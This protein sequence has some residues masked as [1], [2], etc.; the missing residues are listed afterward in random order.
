MKH[1]DS[2]A[3][4]VNEFMGKLEDT[5]EKVAPENTDAL[6][7]L[8]ELRD[9]ANK[10]S[11][12][13]DSIDVFNLNY[14]FK[15]IDEKI[16]SGE[17]S[18]YAACRFDMKRFSVVNHQFG[19]EDGTKILNK[20]IV[21]LQKRLGED[22]C[23]CRIQGDTF[24]VL[25]R[26]KRISFVTNYLSGTMI[27]LGLKYKKKAMLSTYA[28]Y[29]EIVGEKTA[30]E[31]MDRI[32]MAWNIAKHVKRVPYVF[33]DEK[34][35]QSVEN[36]K[37]VESVFDEA[38][39]NEEFMVYY[40]PKVTLKNYR[41][42]GAEALCRW[43]HNGEMVLPY[44]F[45]PV[46]EQSNMICELDFYMLEHVCRDLKRWRDEG[47]ELVKI[48]VNLSR[49]HLGDMDLVEHVLEIVDRYGI[50]HSYIELEL[51]ETTTDVDFRE[52]KQIVIAFRMQGFSVAVDDFGVGYSSLNLIREM[53]WKVLKIDKSFLPEGDEDEDENN[54]KRVMLKHIIGMAQNLG[55]ECIAEGVETAEQVT[56]LKENNCYNAQ[57]YLFDKPLPVE[58][59]EDRLARLA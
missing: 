23:V 35:M 31:I 50:P 18:E 54:Q 9:M 51:T 5:I 13:A 47:R 27:E 10:I 15:T 1:N 46:L 45:I 22:G 48:S 57:G 34:L 26:K 17:L 30:E 42:I 7:N 55:L 52:L 11:F 12:R 38:L 2:Y 32:G 3:K 56:I 4:L 37:W 8:R 25:F 21:G 53:P 14:F 49:V 43:K 20:F 59:F 39:R 6:E 36:E 44:R 16:A 28:G 41:L 33:F 40:Q 29:Y 24:T 58:E 19:R